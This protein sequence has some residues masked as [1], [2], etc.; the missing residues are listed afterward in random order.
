MKKILAIP[1]IAMLFI[2][3]L[4]FSGCDSDDFKF[5]LDNL[6][7]SLFN[8]AID[9]AVEL[10]ETELVGLDRDENVAY[11]TGKIEGW[12]EPLGIL[13]NSKAD[14]WENII[15]NAFDIVSVNIAA[16]VKAKLMDLYPETWEIY[17]EG[18]DPSAIGLINHEDFQEY[19]SE[20]VK[21]LS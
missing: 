6:K 2:S 1:I 8:L 10:I 14:G 19:Y 18:A 12:L 15:G 13:N 3:M 11:L 9:Q 4:F 17:Y 16:K 21:P 7:Q 5:D 20:V